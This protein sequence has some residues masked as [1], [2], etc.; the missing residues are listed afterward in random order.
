MPLSASD[1][2]AM[3]GRLSV[4]SFGGPINAIALVAVVVHRWMNPSGAV[5][6][7]V[8]YSLKFY[9]GLNV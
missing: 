6:E 8:R 3:R 4:V 2:K 7:V 1:S 5:E 9:L